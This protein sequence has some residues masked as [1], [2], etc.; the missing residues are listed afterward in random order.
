MT[1][2]D[3]LAAA[4]ERVRETS[5]QAIQQAL[6]SST[7]DFALTSHGQPESLRVVHLF[8][9][10]YWWNRL[11]DGRLTLERAHWIADP[12][13]LSEGMNWRDHLGD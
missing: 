9:K 1:E 7:S 8:S 4:M 6:R 13:T 12:A 10:A 2:P 11:P 5:R 3:A